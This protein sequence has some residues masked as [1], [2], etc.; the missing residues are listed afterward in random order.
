MP[1]PLPMSGP[2]SP[3]TERSLVR[4]CSGM[5]L[6]PCCPIKSLITAAAM[7]GQQRSGPSG[8]QSFIARLCPNPLGTP[9]IS[10]SQLGRS[11]SRVLSRRNHEL[12]RQGRQLGPFGPKHHRNFP[13]PHSPGLRLKRFKCAGRESDLAMRCACCAVFLFFSKLGSSTQTGRVY[14]DPEPGTFTFI[15]FGQPVPTRLASHFFLRSLVKPGLPA[16]AVAQVRLMMANG[17]PMRTKYPLWLSH[18]GL[19][20]PSTSLSGEVCVFGFCQPPL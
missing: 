1:L 14:F 3:G 18:M 17:T 19:R 8:S 12:T 4:R 9:R 15:D 20:P 6:P 13:Q 11:L 2:W 5:C 7:D 16:K 10:H